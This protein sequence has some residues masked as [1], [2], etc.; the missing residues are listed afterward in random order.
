MISTEEIGILLITLFSIIKKLIR[1]FFSLPLNAF[2]GSFGFG[3]TDTITQVIYNIC[4]GLPGTPGIGI[5]I[6]A[7]IWSGYEMRMVRLINGK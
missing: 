4:D 7:V 3:G 6:L 5:G 1:Y 2:A